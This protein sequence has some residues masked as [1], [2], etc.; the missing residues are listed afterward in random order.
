MLGRTVACRCFAGQLPARDYGSFFKSPTIPKG[1]RL[2]E[3]KIRTTQEGVSRR[4]LA[5]REIPQ[6]VRLAYVS[7]PFGAGPDRPIAPNVF[8]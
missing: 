7:L 5:K 4:P 1:E 3:L 8:C 2:R 6:L